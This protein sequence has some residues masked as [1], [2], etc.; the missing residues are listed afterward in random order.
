VRTKKRVAGKEKY[1]KKRGPVQLK[2][3]AAACYLFL[4]DGQ[5]AVAKTARLATYTRTHAENA[6]KQ[7]SKT[8]AVEN[9][10][11]LQRG[12]EGYEN[13]QGPEDQHG[14]R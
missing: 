1:Q 11:S 12:Q 14:K 4:P 7:G 10:F 5:R 2:L 6:T 13:Q 8:D 9:W 3:H